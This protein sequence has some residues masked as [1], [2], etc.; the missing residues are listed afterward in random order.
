MQPLT[1]AP[2]VFGLRQPSDHRAHRPLQNVSKTHVDCRLLLRKLVNNVTAGKLVMQHLSPRTF[3]PRRLPTQL[4]SAAYEIVG[5]P[6][7]RVR[8]ETSA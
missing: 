5:I 3:D 2:S 6:P 4:A 8:N 7:L 1:T